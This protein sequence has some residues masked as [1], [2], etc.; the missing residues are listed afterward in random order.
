M[1][2]VISI[3]IVLFFTIHSVFH[4]YKQ[5]ERLTC[6]AGMMISMTIAM[7]SSIALGVILGVVAQP[8]LTIPTITAILAG[9][10]AGYASGK[11]ISLMAAMD[12][13]LAA[14]MGGMMGAMLGAML[15]VS[16]EIMLLFVDILFIFIMSVLNQLIDEE[17]GRKSSQSAKMSKPFLGS[18]IGLLAGIVLIAALLFV[19]KGRAALSSPEEV[20]TG[21]TE[22]QHILNGNEGVQIASIPV[23]P[24]GYGKQDVALKAGTSTPVMIDFVTESRTGC[25]RQIISKELG[26]NALLEEGHNYITLKDPKP[27]TYTFTCGMGMYTGTIIIR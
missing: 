1:I 2:T 26:I 23:T 7:M 22:V 9:M 21:A 3:G 11:P 19:E 13:M 12:G 16:S 25:L 14:I 27:G 5:R 10:L 24:S 17:S 15:T 8:D 6:M 20:T 18:V 4:T